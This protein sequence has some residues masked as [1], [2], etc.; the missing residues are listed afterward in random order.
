[1]YARRK[2]QFT[3]FNS[4]TVKLHHQCLVLSHEV[5]SFIEV[6]VTCYTYHWYKTKRKERTDLAG[7][8]LS[9]FDSTGKLNHA[10]EARLLVLPDVSV[11]QNCRYLL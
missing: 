4:V 5:P 11:H 2:P 7:R 10:L 8:G 3:H 1:M 6:L 9:P